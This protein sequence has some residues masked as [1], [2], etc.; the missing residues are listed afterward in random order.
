MKNE[1]LH[2]YP[3][4]DYRQDQGKKEACSQNMENSTF[5]LTIKYS[6]WSPFKEP[7]EGL[8][9]PSGNVHLLELGQHVKRRP[10]GSLAYLENSCL[11]PKSSRITNRVCPYKKGWKPS[12]KKTLRNPLARTL[13]RKGETQSLRLRK[14]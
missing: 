9:T 3:A 12:Q 10:G 11:T 8:Y 6:A 2:K 14:E 5:V 1:L 4:D 7:L 13:T